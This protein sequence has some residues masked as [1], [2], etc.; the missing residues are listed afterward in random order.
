MLNHQS[1]KRVLVGGL[2][3][4]AGFPA[5]A[6][7]RYIEDGVGSPPASQVPVTGPEPA[8]QAVAIPSGQGGGS[9]FQ[10][11]DAGIGAAGA[12]VLISAGALGTGVARRRRVRRTVVG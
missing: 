9:S 7:A 8:S 2:V 10:W 5:V 3:I 6:Q 11:G 4:A 1:I 12:V